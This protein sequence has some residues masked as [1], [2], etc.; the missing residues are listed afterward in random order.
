MTAEKI[1]ERKLKESGIRLT[2]PRRVIAKILSVTRDHPDVDE[3]HNRIKKVD[4]RISLATVYRTLQLFEKIGVADKHDF[5][6]GRAH[7]ESSM[8]QHHDHLIDVRNGKVIEFHSKEIEA[9]Q[10]KI[11]AKHGYRIIDHRLEI[12]VEPLKKP[13]KN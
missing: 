2:G 11:A 10:A 3:L 8:H 12:Y 9:L 7:Y 1:F 13:K 5:G 6:S 4:P